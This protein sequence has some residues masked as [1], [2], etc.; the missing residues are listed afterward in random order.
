[1]KPKKEHPISPKKS[2]SKKLEASNSKT[3]SENSKQTIRKKWNEF[4]DYD[5]M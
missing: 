5:S 3:K 1:M 2:D 4:G